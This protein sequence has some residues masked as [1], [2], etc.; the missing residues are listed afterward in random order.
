M[1]APWAGAF[2]ANSRMFS[3]VAS[4]WSWTRRLAASDDSMACRP[5][6][7]TSRLRLTASPTARARSAEWPDVRVTSS[8]V[9]TVWETA[10]ACSWEPA[11]CCD[12]LARIS[13]LAEAS[14]ATSSRT[15]SSLSRASSASLRSVWSRVTLTKPTSRPVESRSAVSTTLAQKREPSL[16]SRQ[17]SSS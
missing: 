17:P 11:A 8:T 4:T 9:V 14:R 10:A 1:I 13:A 6:R 7:P 12:V 2:S 16:R 5:A 15:L 3:A